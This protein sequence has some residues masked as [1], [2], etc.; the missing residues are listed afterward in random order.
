MNGT[1]PGTAPRRRLR[2]RLRLPLGAALGTGL[3]V[4]MALAVGTTL[5]VGFY[6]ISQNT[7]ELLRDKADAEVDLLAEA[8]A[9]RLGPVVEQARAVAQRIESGAI[10]I[11]AQA[12]FEALLIGATAATPQVQRLGILR[13]DLKMR[14]LDRDRD[15]FVTEDLSDDP[16]AAA[17]LSEAR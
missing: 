14:R 17:A 12:E 16:A 3:A 9:S 4:M 2:R 5:A 10:D 8:V 6:N 1:T 7:R 11:E 15:L 13:P